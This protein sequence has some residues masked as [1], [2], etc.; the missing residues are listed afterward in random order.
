MRKLRH[1]A[2]VQK[3]TRTTNANSQGITNTEILYA[4]VPCQIEGGN[5]EQIVRSFGLQQVA[6]AVFKVEMRWH[7]GI[8]NGMQLIWHDRGTDRT[9]SIIAQPMDS[10]KGRHYTMTLVCKEGI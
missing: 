7:D 3:E 9:L 10:S 4:R 1:R 6:F 8:E 2:S 5:M